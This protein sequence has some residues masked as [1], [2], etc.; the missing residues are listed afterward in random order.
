MYEQQACFSWAP[1]PSDPIDMEK[2]LS[3]CKAVVVDVSAPCVLVETFIDEFV[4]GQCPLVLVA[5]ET[6]SSDR[7]KAL[8]HKVIE[9]CG[10]NVISGR[11]GDI[12]AC[13]Q[14]I[15]EKGSGSLL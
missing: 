9:D 12:Y 14:D 1:S 4:L 7:R 3:N 13:S 6:G 15:M 8:A 10:P 11:L 2:G 5:S